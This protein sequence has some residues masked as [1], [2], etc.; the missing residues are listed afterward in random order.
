[1]ES[2]AV[3]VVGVVRLLWQGGYGIDLLEE[4][5]C[6][7]GPVVDADGLAAAGA[8]VDS[9]GDAF[10]DFVVVKFTPGE[11]DVSAEWVGPE[12]SFGGDEDLA[13]GEV[14]NGCGEDGDGPDDEDRL[15]ENTVE[16][17]EE[18]D[19]E[20]D[21]DGADEAA[22]GQGLAASGG[23]AVGDGRDEG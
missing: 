15:D 6:G 4:F 8:E 12:E 11:Q 2:A 22:A 18:D 3:P 17:D 13:R 19:K 21:S 5:G 9:A 10:A 20:E 23:A 1:M 16:D 14:G 7:L